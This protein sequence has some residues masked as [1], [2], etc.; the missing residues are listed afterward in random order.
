[1]KGKERTRRKEILYEN[2]LQLLRVSPVHAG[3]AAYRCG[4]FQQGLLEIIEAEVMTGR[5]GLRGGVEWL[6]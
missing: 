5:G 6:K 3:T 1:M 2:N 4:H